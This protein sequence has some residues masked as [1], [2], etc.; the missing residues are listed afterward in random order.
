MKSRRV[1]RAVV[2]DYEKLVIASSSEQ[3]RICT[4]DWHI[5]AANQFAFRDR[6]VV[7]ALGRAHRRSVC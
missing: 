3:A 1:N 5:T 6:A 2:R 4:D 7:S